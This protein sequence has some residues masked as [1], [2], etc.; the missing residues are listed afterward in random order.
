MSD[1]RT[2][3]VPCGGCGAP[4]PVL[5]GGQSIT[6]PHCAHAQAIDPAIDARLRAHFHRVEAVLE[7]AARQR[8][9]ARI[10]GF[11]SR[12][13]PLGCLGV[14]LLAG[15]AAGFMQTEGGAA[16]AFG[17]LG[18]VGLGGLLGYLKLAPT[19]RA[20]W[21]DPVAGQVRCEACGGTVSI[22]ATS[23]AIECPFCQ[24]PLRL[25]DEAFAQQ[26]AAVGEDDAA[27]RTGAPSGG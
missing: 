13:A 22:F 11:A 15:G 18:V 23:D 20:E 24:R 9:R 8:G 16:Y 1:A 17:G 14:L 5:L 21:V 26:L 12:R 6:C 4:L 27:S 10:A 3:T 2:A 7:E 19:G 25:T